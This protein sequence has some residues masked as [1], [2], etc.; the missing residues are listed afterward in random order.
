MEY[1]KLTN[2]SFVSDGAAEII[3]PLAYLPRRVFMLNK[4]QF[5]DGAANPGVVKRAWG[6]STDENGTAYIVKNTDGLATDSSDIITS[7]GFSF[8]T[9]DTPQ[10][11]ASQTGTAVSQANPAVVTIVGHGYQTGD[12]VLLTQTTGMLQIAGIPYTITVTGANTFTIPVDSSGFA[13]AATSVTAKQVLYPEIWIPFAVQITNIT[14]AASA[15]ITTAM[16]HGFV[17][18]QVVTIQLPELFG[19]VEIDGLQANVTAITANTITVDINST[20]FTAFAYP[21]SAD[22]AMGTDVPTV[23]PVGD[24]NFGFIGPVVP[25]PPAIPGAFYNNSGYFVIIGIG[26]GTTVMHAT[27]DEIEFEF[28]YPDQLLD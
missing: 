13:A 28:Q 24:T 26:D 27:S 7:G 16:D 19:M 2:G 23:Y 14:Q 5:D 10:F 15:V 18:G 22:F 1:S 17:V 21:T 4:T 6:F 12:V 20:G 3:G 8:I 11:G 25:F 9:R